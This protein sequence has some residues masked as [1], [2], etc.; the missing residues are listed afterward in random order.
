M[1]RMLLSRN[2]TAG[3][4]LGNVYSA[5]RIGPLLRHYGRV[6]LWRSGRQQLADWQEI[7]DLHARYSA[8]YNTSTATH[9]HL[10]ACP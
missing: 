1:L 7:W 2:R 10:H 3:V 4:R 6:L 8:S 9:L 5:V